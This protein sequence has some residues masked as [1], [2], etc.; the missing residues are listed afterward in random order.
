MKISYQKLRFLSIVIDNIGNFQSVFHSLFVF[1]RCLDDKRLVGNS[2]YFW[3]S[4]F[5]TCLDRILLKEYNMGKGEDNCVKKI[6][7]RFGEYYS[8]TTIWLWK[9]IQRLR[10]GILLYRMP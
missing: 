5:L 4:L 9:E 8:E 7:S 2:T 10:S 6:I 1:F 3:K